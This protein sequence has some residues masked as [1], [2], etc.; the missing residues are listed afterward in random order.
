MSGRTPID[1]DELKRTN[2]AFFAL[3]TV[4]VVG[5]VIVHVTK[6]RNFELPDFF[7]YFAYALYVSEW[8]LYYAVTAPLYR[9]YAVVYGESTPYATMSKDVRN[10]RI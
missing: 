3:T 2:T 7:I 9:V 5:R 8:S 1:Q 10:L 6:R 4:F